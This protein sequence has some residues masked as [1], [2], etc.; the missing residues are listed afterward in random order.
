MTAASPAR[1]SGAG[2]WILTVATCAVAW[3]GLGYAFAARGAALPENIGFPGYWSIVAIGS[4]ASGLILAVRRP[5]NAIGWLFLGGGLVWGI[6]QLADGYAAWAVAG[7]G[8][9]TVVARLAAA[10]LDWI[11]IP[12]QASLALVFVLFPEGRFLTR[13]WRTWTI[14]ALALTLVATLANAA[15]D[16]LSVYVGVRNPL[17]VTS[18]GTIAGPALTGLAILLIIGL[19]NLVVRFRRSEGD[20]RQQIKWLVPSTIVIALAYLVYVVGFAI[21]DRKPSGFAIGVVEAMLLLALA[22]IP[23]AIAIGVLKYRLYDIDIVIKKTV[24]FGFLVAL[25]L[26]LAGVVLLLVGLGVVPSLYDTPPLLLIAGLTF[27]LLAFPLYRVATRIA[28]RIVFAGRETPYEVLS[29]F[30]AQIGEAYSDDDVLPRM[31]AVLREGTRAEL[32]TIWLNVGGELRRAAVWPPEAPGT[33]DPPAEA[34]EVHHRGERLGALSVAMPAND[35]LDVRRSKLIHDLAAQAGPVLRNVRLIEEL[36]ASRRRLVAA[37][38]EE[39]RRLERN[40]HDGAQQ[41]LVALAVKQRLAGSLV[42]KDD[43]RARAMLEELQA[44]TNAA[45]EDLRD[46]ARGIYPPLLA[47]KGLVAALQGQ[48]RKAPFPVT[49]HGDGVGRFGQDVEAAVYFSCLEALQNIGK[50]AE[51]SRA[52]IALTNGGGELRFRV[53]DDGRGFDPN[54]TGYGTGLTGIADR[55]AALGGSMRVSSALGRGTTIEGAV[56]IVVG[57]AP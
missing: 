57:D 11:W 14:V 30:S 10:A 12:A 16:P 47:D 9:T 20:E 3:V 1:R 8:A 24:V 34:V 18:L 25:L 51:A 37:Q 46:L 56:P 42:G 35:P 32:A 15:I 4:A 21:P 19:A 29:S 40:I 45:L 6:V 50:Y 39:R 54:P 52:D 49:V 2:A 27:G 44:D 28:D 17:A 5:A 38:D 33:A 53:T 26:A 55:L 13:R 41:Q 22:T 23:I 43:E 36:R 48:A 31:A 7:R